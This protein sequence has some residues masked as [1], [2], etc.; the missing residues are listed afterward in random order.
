VLREVGG[1]AAAY[2]PVGDPEAF[3]DALRR[4]LE[5]PGDPSARRAHAAPYTWARSAEGHRAAYTLALS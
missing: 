3:A 2:A 4:V 1:A 5:T